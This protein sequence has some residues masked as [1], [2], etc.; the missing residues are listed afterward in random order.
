MEN[1][2]EVLAYIIPIK[3]RAEHTESGTRIL[4]G[5]GA[6][7]GL[8]LLGAWQHEYSGLGCSECCSEFC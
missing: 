3:L 4:L 6:F 2:R 8:V 5:P 1:C 7:L